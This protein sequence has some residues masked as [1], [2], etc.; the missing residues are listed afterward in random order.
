V[1]IYTGLIYQGPAVVGRMITGLRQ[2]LARD[3]FRSLTDAVG[4]KSR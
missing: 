4:T 1:Q 3:G 2:L